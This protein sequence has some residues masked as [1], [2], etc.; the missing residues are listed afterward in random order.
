VTRQTGGL[1][2]LIPFSANDRATDPVSLQKLLSKFHPNVINHSKLY[3]SVL[4]ADNPRHSSF[5]KP[6][7]DQL[8]PSL[9]E[10]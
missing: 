9:Y 10:V 6:E 4:Q 3:S 8:P 5:T 1:A 2:L 7:T